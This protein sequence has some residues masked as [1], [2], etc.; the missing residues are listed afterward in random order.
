[1]KY[2]LGSVSLLIA[3]V[4]LETLGFSGGGIVLLGAG[5]ACECWFWVRLVRGRRSLPRSASLKA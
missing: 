2:H 3:A 4:I 5:V 1:M